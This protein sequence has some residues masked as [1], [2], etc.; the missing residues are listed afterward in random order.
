MEKMSRIERS[1]VRMIN[2]HPLFFPVYVLDRKNHSGKGTSKWEPKSR[3]G[4]YCGHH[5]GHSGDMVLVMN[6]Q[7]GHVTPQF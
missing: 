3:L 5:P 6:L 1:H 7:T 4:I 2:E